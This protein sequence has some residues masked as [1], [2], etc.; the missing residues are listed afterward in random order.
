[1]FGCVQTRGGAMTL[2]AAN[3]AQRAVDSKQIGWIG[4]G[5]M[6]GPM[7]ANLLAAGYSVAVS[8]PSAEIREALAGQGAQTAAGLEIQAGADIVFTTLPN[9][10][11][12]LRVVA[13]DEGRAGLADLMPAGSILV[14]MSTVSPGCSANV[15]QILEKAGISY[16]R[17]PISGSTAMAKAASL[18]VL[19]SGDKAAWPTVL[20]LLRLLSSKQ[21]FLGEA[22]E[23]RYMKLVL[24]TLVGASSAILAEAVALGASGGLSRAAMMEV[25]CE[26]AVASPLLK[27]KTDLVVAADY[28]PAFTIDQMIKDFT[29]ISDAGRANGIP[30][31]TAGLI[32][33]LYRAAANAGLQNED[34]FALVKWQSGI[35]AQ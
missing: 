6:G 2:E 24:N 14:E 32:L 34:F 31:M 29:L 13:G 9:D 17:A 7:A 4:A 22:D 26:S 27:Y 21:F 15:A 8:D 28:A 18:T 33:E 16:L 11:V 30:L 5:K 1:M 20:P 25:I 3:T 19:A 23:A 12:L 10:A 35:S